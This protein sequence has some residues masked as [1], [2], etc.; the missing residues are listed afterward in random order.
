MNAPIISLHVKVSDSFVFDVM[1]TAYD[2]PYE[3]FDIDAVQ[4]SEKNEHGYE[5]PARIRVSDYGSMGGNKPLTTMEI[6]PDEIREGIR[7]ILTNDMTIAADH[8]KAGDTLRRDLFLCVINDDASNI[9]A[10]YADCIIQA[11]YFGH[12][13]YQ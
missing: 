8:G 7:R 10:D 4:W 3:W 9:D 12:L 5:R 6:G 13:M 1:Q 2:H 11:A